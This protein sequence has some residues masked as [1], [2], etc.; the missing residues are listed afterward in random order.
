MEKTPVQ[1]FMDY[2]RSVLDADGNGKI[3]LKDMAALFPNSA[4]A[5]AVIFVDLLVLVAEYRVWDVGVKITGDTY[6][7]IGFVLVSAVPFYLGQIFWLY[8]RANGLQKWIG[9]GFVIGGLLTS[10]AFGLADLSL[11]YDVAYIIGLVVQMTVVY[12]FAALGYVL[13]DNT[14]KAKRLMAES[15]GRS[16]QERDY[17]KHLR[18]VLTELQETKRLEKEL[19]AEFGA[20]VVADRLEKFRGGGKST[21]GNQKS[22]PSN[23]PNMQMRTAGAYNAE[24]EQANSLDSPESAPKVVG[25]K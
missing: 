9:G 24:T 11:N 7:A 22:Y 16:D 14:I 1:S 21:V 8:P 15:K 25:P 13:F 23:A 18:T 10:A 19:A 20:D 2:A 4:V 5:I 17:Q 6:K 3:N 12:I